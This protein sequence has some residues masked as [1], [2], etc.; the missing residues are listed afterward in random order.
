MARKGTVGGPDAGGRAR[1]VGTVGEGVGAHGHVGAQCLRRR[2]PRGK[3]KEGEGGAAA[4]GREGKEKRGRG[5]AG[6]RETRNF[7][8]Q[9]WWRAHHR[10]GPSRES[11]TNSLIED[12]QSVELMNRRPRDES[13]DETNAAVPSDSVDDSRIEK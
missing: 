12:E 5:C 8:A 9:Q 1:H 7:Y 13:L 10:R 2:R 6:E 3:G 4:R 11:R